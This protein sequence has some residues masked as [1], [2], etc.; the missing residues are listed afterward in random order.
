MARVGI[1]PARNRVSSYHPARVTVAVLAYVPYLQGYWQNRLDVLRLCLASLVRH[2]T[3][4]YD[5]LIFD[6]GSCAEAKEFLRELQEQGAIR[7]L[8]TAHEN[9]GKS[10][11]LKIMFAAAPGQVIA[12]SDDD[13]F[14]YPGWLE[15]HLRLLDGY[16]SVGMVSGCAVRT[17]FDHGTKSNLHLAE[18]D[19]E[20][21]L[22]HGK[23][24]PLEWEI[25]WAESYGRDV[26][27]HRQALEK[28]E[29]LSLEYRGLEAF[30]IA[31]HN[32][33]VTPRSVVLRAL[34]EAWSGRLMGEMNELDSAI[35]NLGFLR[36]ST[37]ERTTKHI[38]NVVSPAMAEEAGRYSIRLDRITPRSLGNPRPGVRARLLRFKPVRFVLQG[39]YN[40]LFWVLSDQ[41]GGWH[42]TQ[43]GGQKQ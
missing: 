1:N 27:E 41:S 30:A 8:I 23:R 37:I 5:L 34:P 17:L 18:T 22:T 3:A 35:D 33:F 9:I 13:I 36:L 28:M 43:D 38:G 2:T 14:F 19:P 25:E 4:P 7:Y 42:R 29:D 40:R 39:L 15:A 10:G 32:Q 31:N 21:H 20:A 12:Y 6:N 16:P 11:A 26:A 24:I